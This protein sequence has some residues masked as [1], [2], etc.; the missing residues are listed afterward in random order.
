MLLKSVRSFLFLLAIVILSIST[1]VGQEPK[2][3][4]I[5]TCRQDKEKT[6]QREWM[7]EKRDA[8]NKGILV[9]E[10]KVYDDSMLQQMLNAAQ[11]RLLS[12]QVL[13]QTGIAS[14]LGA[15]TGANQSI[16]GF[17]L[18]AQG[19]PSPT[20]ATTNNGATSSTQTTSSNTT[21]T[22][23]TPSATLLS[24]IQNTA[25]APVTNVTTTAPSVSVPTVSAPA[26]ST[27][28]PTSFSGSASDLLNEQMQ[29]TY[30]IANLRL[31]LEGSLND[32]ILIKKDPKGNETRFVKPRV[33]LGFPITL[34]P[35]SR[36]KNAV[37]V[38]EVEIE[39][40]DISLAPEEPPA[41]L[42]LLPRDKTY[43]VA[44]ITD[45]SISI[46][47]GVVTGVSSVAGSFG[48]G[49]KTFYVVQDQD[50]VALTYQPEV[51]DRIG[52]LWQFRPVLGANYVKAGLKQTFVQ[53]AFPSVDTGPFG[54]VYVRTYWRRYDQR[55]GLTKGIQPGSLRE[56]DLPE[57]IQYFSLEQSPS[58]F[59]QSV[60]ED[61]GNGQMLITLKGHFLGA[62]YVRIGSNFLRDGSPGFI[63]EYKQIRF[64]ALI[65]DLATKQV[66]LVSRDGTESPLAIV[67]QCQD[68]KSLP[69]KITN[70]TPLSLDDS[71]TQLIIKLAPVSEGF[72]GLVHRLIVV[73]GS[74]V[75]G[76]GDAPIVTEEECSYDNKDKVIQVT[77][78]VTVPTAFLIASPKVIVK[79]LFLDDKYKAEYLL[80]GLTQGA[81]VPKLSFLGQSG[82]AAK[83]IL[84]GNGCSL[85]QAN[86]LSPA[87]IELRPLGTLASP[88][89]RLISFTKDQIKLQKQLVLQ[90]KEGLLFQIP[91]PS[92]EFTDT[93]KPAI[94]P[95]A[96]VSVGDDE[97]IFQ[98]D[99]MAD[100]IKVVFNG[101]ELKLTKQ[102][103]KMVRVSGLKAAGATEEPKSQT[104]EFFFKSGK[105]PVKVEVSIPKS[106]RR[107]IRK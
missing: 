51:H 85:D 88:Y 2:V 5:D 12:L 83:F 33:T 13:D 69:L 65:S 52:F 79:A 71:N 3:K 68:S 39:K 23:S 106:W 53:I 103:G 91:I 77:I 7:L 19:P 64:V 58:A 6:R 40:A 94:K 102:E 105:T 43:N 1:T 86:V 66:K 16:S 27:S 41:I 29:L 92:V 100:L 73:I 50:T 98:G 45:K 48:H 25:G 24:S 10:I 37:A 74:R 9:G 36:Y 62:T 97:V 31:L 59:N 81:Q 46:G 70:C 32:R 22:G 78:R 67:P 57:E 49:T 75:F 90:M 82:D 56:Y 55:H 107:H 60:F 44:S 15:I 42:A 80:K 47:A 84:L 76:Y 18:S 11:A 14:K 20:I 95:V 38:V 35:D 72:M 21:V 93:T 104:L 61:L 54:K 28:L 87:G 26:P 30:E 63:S 4:K 34:C 101:I 99:G 89:I 96:P 8:D 17:A